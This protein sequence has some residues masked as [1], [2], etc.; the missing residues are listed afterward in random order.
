MTELMLPKTKSRLSWAKFNLRSPT[1]LLSV[2]IVAI[3]LVE[4]VIMT[5]VLLAPGG[6]LG[7]AVQTVPTLTSA[8]SDEYFVDVYYLRDVS[9]SLGQPTDT[10]VTVCIRERVA[11]VSARVSDFTLAITSPEGTHFRQIGGIL[12]EGINPEIWAARLSIRHTG[13]IEKLNETLVVHIVYK[14]S[15]QNSTTVKEINA[16]LVV[17]IVMED[18][19][20]LLY[21]GILVFGVFASYVTGT[22]IT[23]VDKK[24]ALKVLL[25]LGFSAL[26]GVLAFGQ[27]RRQVI[28]TTEPILNFALAFGFGFASEK[29][30]SVPAPLKGKATQTPT[31][32][33]T[34][35]NPRPS[36]FV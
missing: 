16:P 21:L 10:K 30:L 29:I 28:L 22:D 13:K 25:W 18:F 15:S 9:V 26:V 5:Y 20:E 8:Q 27:F 19:P 33:R 4:V 32:E 3:L 17:N 35:L 2:I 31:C 1:S 36:S 11:N 12:R 6:V 34:D 7:P 14:I 24:T 23:N